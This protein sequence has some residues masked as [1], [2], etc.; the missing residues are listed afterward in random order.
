MKTA[1]RKAL[2]LLLCLI[3]CLGLT[4]AALAAEADEILITEDYEPYLPA[5]DSVTFIFELSDAEVFDAAGD[6]VTISFNANGGAGTMESQDFVRGDAAKPLNPNTF[7]RDGYYFLGWNERADGTAGGG[8]IINNGAAMR[9]S[10][11]SSSSALTLYAQWK[12]IGPEGLTVTVSFDPNGGTGTMAAQDFVRGDVVKPLNL[13]TFTRSGYTFTHW[14]TEAD[15]S[16]TVYQNG[17]KIAPSEN[18]TLYAQWTEGIYVHFD[19]NGASGTRKAQKFTLGVTGKLVAMERIGYVMDGYEFVGWAPVSDAAPNDPRIIPDGGEFTAE[20]ETTL[21]A[22][23]KKVPGIAIDKANFPDDAFRSYVSAN[24]DQNGDGELSKYDIDAVTQINVS[25]SYNEP[26]TIQS[27]EGI[28]Y[29]TELQ[30]LYCS[31]NLLTSLDLSQNTALTYLQCSGNQLTSLDVSNN[32]AL[33]GLQC[34]RNQLTSLDISNNT[35]LT[36]L[37]CDTNQLASLDVSNNTALIS[38]QC[39]TNQLASL[40]VSNNTALISLQCSTNQLTSLDISNNTALTSLRCYSNQL[41]DLDVS[42]NIALTSLQCNRNQLASLAVNRNTALTSLDCSNNQLTSL[43]VGNNTALTSLL[44]NHNQLATLDVSNNTAL[45]SLQCS[46]NPLGNL[47]VSQNTALKTLYCGINWLTGLDLSNN[48]ALTSLQCSNNQLTSLDISPCPHLVALIE[49]VNP[50]IRTTYIEFRENNSILSFDLSTALTPALSFGAGIAID[51]N[52]FPDPVF[53]DYVKAFDLDE[54]GELADAECKGVT[55]INVAGSYNNSN[56]ITSLEGIQHFTGLTSLIC[57]INQLTSLDL[58]QNT[59]LTFLNCNSNQLT[60][61]D[62]SKNSALTSLGCGNNQLTSLDL[63]HT[64]LLRSLSCEGNLLTTLDIS[65]CPQLV[66]LAETS[67]PSLIGYV[68]FRTGNNSFSYDYSVKLTPA[69]DYGSG[70]V[71]DDK[72]FPD[73]NFLAYVKDLDIDGNGVFSDTE[74]SSVA[75]INVRG[76]NITSLQGIELFPN[77]TSLYCSNNQLT[78]LSLNGNTALTSLSCDNNPLTSLDVSNNATLTY[79]NC[80]SNQLTNLDLHSNTALIYLRCAN[81]RLTSLDLSQNTALMGLSCEGNYL[82]VLDLSNSS[83]LSMVCNAF[84]PQYVDNTA[85]Y[86][87]KDYGTGNGRPRSDSLILFYDIG[88]SIITAPGLVLPAA[89]TEIGEEAF[90][91]SAFRYVIVPDT[92]TAISPCAFADCEGLAAVFIP[93]RTIEIAPNAFSGISNL[94]VVGTSDSAAHTFAQQRGFYYVEHF[95]H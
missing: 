44:C 23:W 84:E 19:P 36:S 54:N 37:Q 72:Q 11:A 90:A 92:V 26:G 70:I 29:F 30:R 68:S 89:L 83:F 80:S 87:F 7:T 22:I 12:E 60:S 69:L 73:P 42:N 65:Q 47:D 46:D 35:A 25:G 48:V 67:L 95:L 20:G 41:K 71:V 81:N 59:A 66:E 91:D 82:T 52:A 5:D 6:I 86:H 79:L 38:L 55:Q 32:A 40:D 3:L 53:R 57:A 78:S 94:V 88:T 76:L 34:I 15:D 1:L 77:L 2:P 50:T 27:L 85:E 43:D 28:Q 61:L 21:Y 63:S 58:S 74:I 62:L 9:L 4:P 51:E 64:P 14:T 45:T 17:A 31:Y 16:G 93:S 39:S 49:T 75:G 33:T 56:L 18:M 10:E 24:L 8:R 13:N